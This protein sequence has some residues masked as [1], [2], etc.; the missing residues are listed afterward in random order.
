MLGIYLLA[1]GF[2]W[3]RL[4]KKSSSAERRYW[5]GVAFASLFVGAL[6]AGLL[7]KFGKVIHHR[8]EARCGSSNSSA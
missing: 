3:A 2:V 1:A 4:E 5:A 6:L 8:A 7:V